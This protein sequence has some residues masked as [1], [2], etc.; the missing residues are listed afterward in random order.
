LGVL[1]L[2]GRWA[3]A[4]PINRHLRKHIFGPE[5]DSAWVK[6]NIEEVGL[7]E[8]FLPALYASEGM[9]DRK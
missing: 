1:D 6:H 5:M 7:F 4:A 9:K 3:V 8:H 2:G